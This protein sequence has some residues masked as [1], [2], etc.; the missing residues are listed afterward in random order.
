MIEIKGRAQFLAS[1]QLSW[2]ILEKERYMYVPFCLCIYSHEMKA[3]TE[4]QFIPQ[5]SH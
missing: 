1:H 4:M 3:V 2:K 5:S